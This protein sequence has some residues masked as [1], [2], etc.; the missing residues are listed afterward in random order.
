MGKFMDIKDIKVGTRTRKIMGDIP[1]FAKSL[2]RVGLLH[3][4]V[5]NSSHELISGARRLA[6]AKELGW[7][8]V[9]ATVCETLDDVELALEAERD[10][11]AER[12]NPTPSEAVELAKLI[13]PFE[14]KT[15]ISRKKRTGVNFTP[16]KSAGKS[17]DR[18]AAAVGMS[19]PTLARATAVVE[20]AEQHPGAYGEI[21][22]EMDRTG[23]VDPAY[24]RLSERS[25]EPDAPPVKL[26]HKVNGKA[27]SE[28]PAVVHAEPWGQ[29][30]ADIAGIISELRSTSSKLSKVLGWNTDTK[31]LE[32]PWAHFYSHAGTAGQVN[33]VVRNL[34]DNL[35]AATDP[36]SPGYLPTR[37]VKMRESMA[38]KK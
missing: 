38:N 37:S 13:A 24:K 7:T 10:E 25:S 5:L 20:A 14:Q 4:L 27:K 18:V 36:K 33:A 30:N 34:E 12:L 11:N 31:R 1:R 19:A 16:Q 2:A 26:P 28:P 9:P 21:A 32:N 29:F 22:Q 8:D 15:A 6:A 17:R 35:P 3:P 23:K